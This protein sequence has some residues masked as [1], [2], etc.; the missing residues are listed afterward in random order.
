MAK[1]WV[2]VLAD[3]FPSDSSETGVGSTRVCN[4]HSIPTEKRDPVVVEKTQTVH[5][6]PERILS[7]AVR[8]T[9]TVDGPY[10]LRSI[11]AV[12]SATT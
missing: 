6:A 8:M 4:K 3:F 11:Q 5:E 7:V 10:T 9:L 1:F 12:V 2:F